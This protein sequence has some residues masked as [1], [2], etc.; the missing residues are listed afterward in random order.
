MD[1]KLVIAAGAAKKQTIRL[2]TEETLIGRQKGCDL[3]IPSATVSRRHCLL[4]FQEEYL[5][6]EDLDSSNGTFLNGERVTRKEVVRP[7][8]RLEIGPLVFLVQ[9]QLTPAAIDRL[10][11][12]DPLEGAA[13]E[14][15][16][17]LP[18]AE[19]DP[20]TV[21]VDGSGPEG[22]DRGE[23]AGADEVVEGIPLLDDAEGWQLP[24]AGELRDIL[25]HLD[26]KNR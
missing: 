9:Y 12:G 20:N 13:E 3:R 14:F 4:R 6:V 23:P 8:D 11:R 22:T 2:R 26:D 5:T 10:L 18:L 25:S 17:A 7:G 1:V 19:D 21:K 15:V 16:E 24:E